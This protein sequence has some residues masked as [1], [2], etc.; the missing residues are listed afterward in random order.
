MLW[1]IDLTLLDVGRVSRDAYAD[2]FRRVTGRPLAAL[3]QLA[4]RSDSEIF[5][6]SLYLNDVPTGEDEVADA[7]LLARYCWELETAFALRQDGL[8]QQGRL[9][10]GARAAVTATAALPG[11]VQ[12]VLTGTIKPNA[13]AKLRAF[14]LDRLFDLEI[15][16]YG[17]DAYPRGSLLLLVRG[18]AGDKY[19][20]AVAS[21]TAVYIAD[22]V[23]DI[24]AAQL[25]GA[26]SIA[27]GTGRDTVAELRDAG[28]DL[29]LPDLSDTQQVTSAIDRLT[30]VP[31]SR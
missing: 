13:V 15:G 6:E 9:L 31:A 10:P 16:G 3:P 7:E 12:T 18:Q 11:V 8:V 21:H 28:A 19:G 1:N 26:R 30:R 5:F 24:E 25:G 29:V 22:T 17:S 27:V 14:G 23:R 20:T 4:G 2:A